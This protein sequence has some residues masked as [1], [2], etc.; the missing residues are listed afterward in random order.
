MT[1]SAPSLSTPLGP[2]GFS[3]EVGRRRLPAVPD[4]CRALPD[5]GL[6]A[7]WNDR[8]AE[9]QLLLTRFEDNPGGLDYLLPVDVCWGTVW[10]VTARQPLDRLRLT[11]ALAGLPEGAETDYEGTQSSAAI[12][13]AAPGLAMTIAT[14]DEEL[15]CQRAEPPRHGVPRRWSE[16]L[17]EVWEYKHV[18][19]WGVEYLW[20]APGFAWV[21]PE[22]RPGEELFLETNVCWRT[23]SPDDDPEDTS[24]WWAAFTDYRKVLAAAGGNPFGVT[25]A[26]RP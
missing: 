14:P 11:S 6:V 2:F 13:V 12:G 1:A 20:H 22:L 15:L 7:R 18:D 26:V 24:T 21:L 17:D 16:L 9:V 25:T 5:G 23:T 8:A 4:E 3:V 19:R 10:R